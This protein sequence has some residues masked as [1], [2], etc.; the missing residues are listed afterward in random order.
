MFRTA[1]TLASGFS[2]DI[3]VNDFALLSHGSSLTITLWNRLSGVLQLQYWLDLRL[4][5]I[6]WGT[7]NKCENKKLS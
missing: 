1:L 3:E 2:P 5:K 6:F 4:Q 7:T